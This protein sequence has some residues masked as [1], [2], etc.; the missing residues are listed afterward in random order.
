[1]PY[2]NV[3]LI[4]PLTRIQKEEIA[5]GITDLLQKV[6]GKNPKSTNVYIEEVK[7]E[8]WS[9]EGKLLG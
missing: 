3:K 4:G 6:A 7:A 8:N 5:K 1:M 9:T 2:V